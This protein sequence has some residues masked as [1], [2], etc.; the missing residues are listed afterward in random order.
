MYSFVYNVTH[1]TISSAIRP[2][3][4][5]NMRYDLSL[6][7]S[8]TVLKAIKPH[9]GNSI[10]FSPHT[11]AAALQLKLSSPCVVVGGDEVKGNS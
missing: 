8:L 7:K 6:F 5:S 1:L 3:S 10:D 2:L 11:L 4:V 9:H